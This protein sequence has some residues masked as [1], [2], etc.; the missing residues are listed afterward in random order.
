[1]KHIFRFVVLGLFV[2]LTISACK[3]E[4]PLINTATIVGRDARMAPCTGVLLL[5]SMA[6]LIPT[7]RKMDIL[8]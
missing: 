5:K 7:I 2:S 6:I 4:L 3:K 8:I 1:M